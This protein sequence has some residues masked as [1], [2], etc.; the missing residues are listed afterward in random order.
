MAGVLGLGLTGCSSNPDRVAAAPKMTDS[1]MEKAIQAR[2]NANPA[3][4]D[5]KVSANAKENEATISGTVATEGLRTE[6]VSLAKGV[7]TGLVVTDKIDVKPH[8]LT[9]AEYTEDMAREARERAKSAG[10]KIGN[11]IE[12]AWI[13]TKITAKLVKDNDTPAHK[14]NVDVDNQ[15]VTLRGTVRT[16]AAKSEAERIAKET[17]GVK[18]VINMLK[19][20]LS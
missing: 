20:S 11:A 16:A 8:E 15:V 2:W 13:H 5:L 14:I 10:D 3:F 1:E 6:A 7:S 9:R 12:D 19:I 17:D 18:R 4:N